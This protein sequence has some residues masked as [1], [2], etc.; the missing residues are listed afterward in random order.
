M[1][2]INTPAH[3]DA[4][5]MTAI[6]AIARC[7]A[8]F[9]K[10]LPREE[11]IELEL[12]PVPLRRPMLDYDNINPQLAEKLHFNNLIR[13]KVLDVHDARKL[14]P[15]PCPPAIQLLLDYQDTMTK[16]KQ[17]NEIDDFVYYVMSV[18]RDVRNWNLL[19]AMNE[20]GVERARHEGRM[21]KRAIANM[22]IA[23]DHRNGTT[24]GA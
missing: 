15:V 17:V 5:E 24:R 4:G 20:L 2:R 3:I 21:V 14:A 19:A 23:I 7:I 12:I 1:I 11:H 9:N 6:W 13:G 16:A 18:P 10:Q 22:I 8:D